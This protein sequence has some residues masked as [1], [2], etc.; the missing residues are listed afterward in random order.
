MA[1]ATIFFVNMGEP[2]V[3]FDQIPKDGKEQVLQWLDV[4]WT[5][6]PA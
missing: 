4:I 6:F 5:E 2:A 3:Y 1:P